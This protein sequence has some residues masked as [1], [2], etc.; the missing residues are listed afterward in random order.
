MPDSLLKIV[1][2]PITKQI[3]SYSVDGSQDG[4]S[5]IKCS[6][7]DDGRKTFRNSNT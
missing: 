5:T 4:Q 3:L 7:T 1:E 6:P 2:T